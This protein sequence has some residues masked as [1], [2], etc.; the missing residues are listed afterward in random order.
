MKKNSGFTLVE[1]SIVIVIIGL[2]VAGVTAGQS[3]VAAAK[4]QSQIADFRKYDVAYKTFKLEYNAIPGDFENAQDYW[5]GGVQ[6]GDGNGR[7]SNHS[8]LAYNS[9]ENR[10]FFQHLSEANLLP[11]KYTNTWE[12]GL[13]YP[14]LK[15]D[16][17]KG[18]IAAGAICNTSASD[19]QLSPPVAYKLIKAALFLN[20]SQP[21]AAGSVYNDFL[22]VASPQTF[23]AMDKK[24]DDGV[25]NS[26][27]SKLTLCGAVLKETV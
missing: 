3:L 2:I 4:M 13:G 7:I 25:A 17:S 26:D 14:K 9:N 22:G 6:D 21:T 11:T 19:Y 5:G 27:F 18:M 20:V 10:W 15:L 24:F 12:L 16:S 1:L 23:H 8:D